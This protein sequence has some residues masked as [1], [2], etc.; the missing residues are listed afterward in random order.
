HASL[1]GH[2]GEGAV[3]VVVIEDAVGVLG[4]VEVG[5]AVAVVV[6]DSNA[7]AVGVAWN[8]GLGGDIGKGS[9]AVV[10]IEGIAQRNGGLVEVAGAAIDE[11]DVHPAV[12]VV[13]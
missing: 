13:V 12:V 1:G 11:V 7:H 3:A 9:I 5:E 4:D 10:A 2:V 8:A 6:T